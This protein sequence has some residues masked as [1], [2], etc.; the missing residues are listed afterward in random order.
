MANTETKQVT[1]APTSLIS[2]ERPDFLPMPQE[3][4]IIRGGENIGMDDLTIPR[5]DVIQDLSPCRKKTDPAYIEGAEEGM[6]VNNVTKE[7]YT[8]SLIIVPAYFRKEWLI[9]K[10][11]K[12]GGGFRGAHATE[13]LANDA[14]NKM[15]DGLACEV[16]ATAQ[17]FCVVINPATGKMEEATLSMS[18]S[19]LKVS[20]QLNSLIKINLGDSFS[21]AY[22]L[23]VVEA[24]N[25][26][27]QAYYN[28][29]I[30][31]MGFPS[32]AA[33]ELAIKLYESA[34][35]GRVKADTTGL[36]E[37]ITPTDGDY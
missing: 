26:Q 12:Q 25:P 23:S 3:A 33:Y 34:S 24:K 6:M 18:R 15:E 4:D 31:N 17:H 27:N 8:E 16:V 36:D 20:R 1:K 29:N 30:S 37:V 22:L 32:K 5:I 9:W 19:K 28:F 10:D 2:A 7:L 11:R 13:A 35:S 14:I 21:R